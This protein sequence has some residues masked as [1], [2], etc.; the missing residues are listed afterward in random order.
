MSQS[1]KTNHLRVY[2]AQLRR[3]LEGD[4][5]SPHYLITGPGMEYRFE[6]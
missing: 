6:G 1:N 4:P 5:S 2:M 3:K